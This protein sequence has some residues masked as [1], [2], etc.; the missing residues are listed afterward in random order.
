MFALEKPTFE[1]VLK[2]TA[3]SVRKYLLDHGLT[4]T[5]TNDM[6]DS[7]VYYS[8]LGGKKLRP[9]A[10]MT[11]CGA[12]GGNPER[13]LP[14]AAAV[15]LYHTWTLVHDDI[16]DRDEKRRWGDS[17]HAKWAKIA[18]D[19]YRWEKSFADHYGLIIGILAG[20]LQKGWSIGG[21]LPLLKYENNVRPEVV[22]KL[23]KE[24]DF[25]T[26]QLLVDGE[27]D[28]VIFSKTPISDVD[29]DKILEMLWKKT[30]SLY[31][32]CGMSGAMVGLDTDDEKH[33]IVSKMANFAAQCGLAFQIQDDIL[34]IIGKEDQLG[35]PAGSDLRE[36]KKTLI[37]HWAFKNGSP[38]ERE[39]IEKVLGNPVVSVAEVEAAVKDMKHLGAIDYAKETATAYIRGGHVNGRKIVGALEY[40]DGLSDS[41]HLRLLKDWAEYLVNRS[42]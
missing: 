20:D 27:L 21:L 26:L 11:S 14:L 24:L 19:T 17:V 22:L 29:E 38:I 6:K 1:S 36:G 33:P 23:I 9:F 41:P 40:L 28:D 10:V 2:E 30:G 7:A 5:T 16:I 37:I 3:E 13:A 39:R 42:F 12:V 18:R 34:G 32:F 4:I 31:R 15:E 35:K 8:N 25:V